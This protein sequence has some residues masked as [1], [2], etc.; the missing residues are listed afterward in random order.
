MSRRI[1]PTY[2][3]L[4]QITLAAASTSVTFSNIPQNYGD[5]VLVM[6]GT[7][8]V[9]PTVVRLVFNGDTGTSNYSRVLMLGVS[10]GR[11][12]SESSNSER[13]FDYYT[14]NPQTSIAQIMDYSAADKNKIILSRWQG[15]LSYVVASVNRWANNSPITNIQVLAISSASIQ[16]GTTISIYGIAA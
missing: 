12:L 11:R 10:D 6:N 3:L 5:L 14:G 2:I 1:T 9:D 13:F 16:S 7:G 15:T 4:N 8:T